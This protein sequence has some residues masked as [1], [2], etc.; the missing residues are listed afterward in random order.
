MKA[1]IAGK[2][3][4]GVIG[5]VC[6][7]VIALI[8]GFG[9]G[10]WTLGSTAKKMTDEAVL[11]YGTE[12]AICVSEFMNDPAHEEKLKEFGAIEQHWERTRFIEK[13]S[14]IKISGQETVRPLVA[15]AC[16]NGLEG[17]I[18]K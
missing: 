14:W 10:G 12:A 18:K 3:K 9:W 6:G 8:I 16:A 11:K 15:E 2:V 7:A 13:G 5:L 17:L 1:E 4:F